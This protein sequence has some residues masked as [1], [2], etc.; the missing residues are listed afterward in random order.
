MTGRTFPVGA[1]LTVA[2]SALGPPYATI[3]PYCELRDLYDIVGWLVGDIPT[4][5][6]LTGH[7]GRARTALLAQHPALGDVHGAPA[8]GSPDTAVLSWLA[9]QEAVFGPTVNIDGGQVT[10]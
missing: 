7:T 2:L 10:A 5:E 8:S 9:A 6:Q 3:G 4:V 1:A